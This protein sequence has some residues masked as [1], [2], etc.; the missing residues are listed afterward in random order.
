MKDPFFKITNDVY[1][2]QDSRTPDQIE[3]KLRRLAEDSKRKQSRI[4][5]HKN[6]EDLIHI[7]YICHLKNCHVR[8]HKHTDNPEWIIFQKANA[9]IIYYDKN[10]KQTNK[11]VIDTKKNGSPIMQF[12]PKFIFHNLKFKEDSYF[13]EIKQGPFN[14]DATKYLINSQK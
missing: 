12:I 4:C 13:L 6:D 2:L 9:E 7:M 8:I 5:L 3:G 1:R 11:F 10:G 14:K